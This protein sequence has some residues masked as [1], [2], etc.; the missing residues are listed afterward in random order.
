MCIGMEVGRPRGGEASR[1][2]ASTCPFV[3]DSMYDGCIIY[4]SMFL[5]LFPHCDHM[6][7]ISLGCM[8]LACRYGK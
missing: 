7:V 1:L 6:L 5:F 3:C 2:K 4:F 8:N